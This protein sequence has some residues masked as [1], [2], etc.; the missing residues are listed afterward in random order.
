MLLGEM[1]PYGATL[2]VA[3]TILAR[4][5][6]GEW[7]DIEDERL[8]ARWKGSRTYFVGYSYRIAELT[9]ELSARRALDDRATI[10]VAL[11]YLLALRAFAVAD[12]R[13]I[14]EA[15]S[16]PVGRTAALLS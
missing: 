7:L 2:Y 15:Y 12:D 9:S 1:I 4:M 3:M 16:T 10:S 13:E 8:A 5:P 11:L 14:L 6:A